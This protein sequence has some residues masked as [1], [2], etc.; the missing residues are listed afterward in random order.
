MFFERDRRSL[1]IR[2]RRVGFVKGKKRKGVNREYRERMRRSV[3]G[4]EE[5][6]G[7]KRWEET[8]TRVK[9][10]RVMFVDLIVPPDVYPLSENTR[11]AS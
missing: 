2:E 7:V 6:G 10:G 3:E 4:R 8:G 5:K 11:T 9:R 1:W